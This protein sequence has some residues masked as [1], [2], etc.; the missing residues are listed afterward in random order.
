MLSDINSLTFMMDLQYKEQ[1]HTGAEAQL[2]TA[3]SEKT[4]EKQ[5]PKM[6]R[7]NADRRLLVWYSFVYLIMRVHVSN[8]SNSTIMNLEQGTGIEKQLGNLMSQQWA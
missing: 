7:R 3:M 4:A 8:I 6:A 2:P 5:I 1:S